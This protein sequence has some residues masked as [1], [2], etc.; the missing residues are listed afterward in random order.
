[1]K[2]LTGEDEIG[3]RCVRGAAISG[4]GP[5]M[6]ERGSTPIPDDVIDFLN[7]HIATVWALELLLL[8]RQNRARAWT[9]EEMA[10]ELRASSQV[11]M[12]VIPPLT[13]AGVV[14]ETA[15]RWRYQPQRS[16]L[17]ETIDRL[18]AVYKQLPVTIIRH[19][20]L[21]PHRE[22]QGFADAF[23]FRKE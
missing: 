4:N 6:T 19:I 8:M 9:I 21:A 12:R 17:D 15:G 22:A 10:K 23:K 14:I 7:K 13:A 2:L 11:I 18:D 5:D 16:E 3:L 20:A 1:L